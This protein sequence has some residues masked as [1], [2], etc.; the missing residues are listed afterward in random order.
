MK[1]TIDLAN[2]LDRNYPLRTLEMAFQNIKIWNFSG[3]A[4]PHNLLAV[5]VFSAGEIHQWLKISQF[6]LIKSLDSLSFLF[7][8]CLTQWTVLKG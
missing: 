4:W 5:R 2:I 6:Y 1:L 7:T 3:G 8:L